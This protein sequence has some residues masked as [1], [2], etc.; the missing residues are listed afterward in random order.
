M[1]RDPYEAYA[2]QDECESEREEEAH[3]EARS[4]SW[5]EENWEKR[6]QYLDREADAGLEAEAY[7]VES[8]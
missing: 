7:E 1:S 3:D 4:M 2:F 6:E 8:C 5:E